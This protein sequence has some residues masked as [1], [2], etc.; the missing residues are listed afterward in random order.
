MQVR[1]R[2]PAGQ[3]VLEARGPPADVLL[4][5]RLHEQ[6]ALLQAEAGCPAGPGVPVPQQ[7]SQLS[8]LFQI[9]T[10]PRG[11]P[12]GLDAQGQGPGGRERVGP[13]VHDECARRVG[14]LDG[15]RRAAQVHLFHLLPVGLVRQPAAGGKGADASGERPPPGTDPLPTHPGVPE[16]PPAHS[17]PTPSPL[18]SS[19]R[20]QEGLATRPPRPGFPPQRR[21]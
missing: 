19:G 3:L 20:L 18:C 5:R 1:P 6:P 16:Q 7:Q 2:A 21:L 12:E 13:Q 10:G 14:P 11:A 4:G 9:N 8:S 15:A 17:R